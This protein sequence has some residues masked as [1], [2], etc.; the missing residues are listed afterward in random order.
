MDDAQG[1]NLETLLEEFGPLREN[2][3]RK[4]FQQIV[5]AVDYCHKRG[6]CVRN[7]KLPNLVLDETRDKVKVFDFNLS[8]VKCTRLKQSVMLCI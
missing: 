5:T 3:A 7:L 1:G 8:K 6:T 2:I 4:Y